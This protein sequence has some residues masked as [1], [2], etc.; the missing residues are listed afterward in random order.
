MLINDLDCEATI[1]DTL[2][3]GAANASAF[4]VTFAQYGSAGADG[5]ASANGNLVF[6][7]INTD[8][9]ISTGPSFAFSQGTANTYAAATDGNSFA[10][11]SYFGQSTFTKFKGSKSKRTTSFQTSF[12]NRY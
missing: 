11:A 10:S 1:S 8:A 5:F 3:K 4:G 7:S 6:S 9:Q 2:I 12:R